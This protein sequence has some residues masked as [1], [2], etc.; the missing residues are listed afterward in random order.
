LEL[1]GARAEEQGRKKQRAHCSVSL[2]NLEK[3]YIRGGNSFLSQLI[4]EKS[5]MLYEWH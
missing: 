1:N 3:S 4:E 5:T 2:S